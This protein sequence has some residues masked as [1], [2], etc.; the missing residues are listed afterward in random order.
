VA[1]K[2]KKSATKR[3]PTGR[4]PGRPRRAQR[5]ARGRY[6]PKNEAFVNAYFVHEMDGHA[7]AIAAGYSPKSARSIA[8]QL[9]NK[10]LIMNEIHK[11]LRHNA[12]KAD[13]TSERVL[14]ELGTIGFSDL[15]DLLELSEDGV[16][17]KSSGE[18]SE[19]A[20]RAL[21][22][23]KETRNGLEVRLHDKKG[24]LELLGRHL[25]MFRE[26]IEHSGAIQISRAA[27]DLNV[28]LESIATRLLTG[29]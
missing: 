10:P 13:I 14:A 6:T 9:L 11:R 23:I 27:E 21:A 26:H 20:A 7:A 25:G 12:K 5:D 16:R 3:K 28:K 1:K 19:D 15:R 4:A 22:A 18:I 17:L 29:G 24:A 2:R 8:S